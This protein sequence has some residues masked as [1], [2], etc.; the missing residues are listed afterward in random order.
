M[1]DVPP[2]VN[3]CVWASTLPNWSCS[4]SSQLSSSASP[5]NQFLEKCPAWK[6][7]WDSPIPPKSSGF[8]LCP[9]DDSW[10]KGQKRSLSSFRD[11]VSSWGILDQYILYVGHTDRVRLFTCLFSNMKN[12]WILNERCSL[13]TA[14]DSSD[15]CVKAG[16]I[17]VCTF[18]LFVFYYNWNLNLSIAVSNNQRK[19]LTSYLHVSTEISFNKGCTS[20]NRFQWTILLYF[21]WVFFWWK[22]TFA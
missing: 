20:K 15:K 13:L 17:F 11:K 8:W 9:V 2:Q 12:M 18:T 16:Y 19:A 3:V 6:A 10:R 21:T 1:S 7:C 4:F 5:S 22:S 14:S